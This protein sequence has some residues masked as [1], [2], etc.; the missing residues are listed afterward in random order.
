[1]LL[2]KLVP[3]IVVILSCAAC[4]PQVPDDLPG[5]ISAMANND[6]SIHVAATRK[7]IQ[8]YGGPGLRKALASPD[9]RSRAEAA[10]GLSF[11]PGAE[12][13]R[14]L[15]DVASDSDEFV[16]GWVAH[17]LG[18]SDP[19]VVQRRSTAWSVTTPLAFVIQP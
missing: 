2:G 15:L 5:L 14:A 3:L 18:K 6:Q 11:C 13:E 17:S 4:E 8:R 19:S 10:L 1:M 16:R 12:N 9:Y 7:V